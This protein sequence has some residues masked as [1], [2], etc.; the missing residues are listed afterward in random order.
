M[1]APFTPSSSKKGCPKSGKMIRERK[2]YQMMLTQRKKEKKH[3]VS[4]MLHNCLVL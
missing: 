1:D 3:G 2:H 4:M